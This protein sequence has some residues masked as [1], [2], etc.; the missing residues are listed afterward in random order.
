MGGMKRAHMA[1]DQFKS[2]PNPGHK[3]RKPA[4]YVNRWENSKAMKFG[5]RTRNKRMASSPKSV[6]YS[7]SDLGRKITFIECPV[8]SRNSQ[9]FH[10]LS[11]FTIP[12]SGYYYQG[13]DVH[14]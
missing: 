4:S 7:P 13:G 8:S 10:G 12:R 5:R 11:V 14:K 2:I 3:I 1:R 9:D 6:F